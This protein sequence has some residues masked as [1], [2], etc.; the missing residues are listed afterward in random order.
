ML[1]ICRLVRARNA[2]RIFSTTPSPCLSRASPSNWAQRRQPANLLSTAPLPFTSMRAFASK[3][4]TKKEAKDNETKAKKEGQVGNIALWMEEVTKKFDTGRVLFDNM[5]MSFY[6]GAKVGILGVN[7]S[8]KSTMLKILAGVEKDFD[9]K[10]I[11]K[12]GF[13]MGYLAQEP[14]LDEERT[15]ME[16]IMEGVKEK[17]DLLIRYENI[18]NEFADPDLTDD[19]M[20]ELIEE[21]AAL[22]SQIEDQ[23]CWD[24][25]REVG[26]AM[27]ALRCPDP[28]VLCGRL[29]GGQQRR[30]A[31]CRLLLSKPDILLLDEPTNHLD[32]GSVYWLERFLADYK[33]LVI[34]ITHDRYFLDNVA[35]WILEIDGGACYPFKGNYNEWLVN[36]AQRS[37]LT[38]KTDAQMDKTID[39]EITWMQ[40][41]AKGGRT[42]G[43]AREGRLKSMIEERDQ[44]R[45]N[46]RL[47]SGALIIPEGKRLGNNVIK[48]ENLAYS[49]EGRT[50]FKD[51]SFTLG[52][53][54]M[55]GIVG[56]NGTGKT[57]LLK[58]LLG[59]LQPDKGEIEIGS[60]VS[61][62]YNA[63]MRGELQ[64]D[65]IVWKEIC[66]DLNR[67]QIAPGQEMHARQYVAQF[68]FPSD[69]QRKRI[70]Q[71]SGGERN[72]VHLAKSMIKGCNV[73]LLDE[74]TN[75]LDVDTLRNLEEALNDFVAIGAGVVVSHDRWFLDRVCTNILAFEK[76]D[77]IVWFK[78]TY[79]EY[80]E[81]RVKRLGDGSLDG[82]PKY[83]KLA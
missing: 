46:R 65:N 22:I 80:M 64:A 19:K 18:S 21:Q 62:A 54:V 28:D 79:S 37:D 36:R 60:T 45:A 23:M 31:L 81:D 11:T 70:G 76:D 68:N 51:L 69:A 52:Q 6:H 59:E 3:N 5:S 82:K 38:R 4:K 17:K 24:L 56:P 39:R 44:M 41:N 58:M 50:L 20:N 32:A 75:D 72:R 63:Q 8:G 13:K 83:K 67:V 47:E 35:G 73:I 57:T 40:K 55:L 25:D 9:G 1:S 27:E 78:G 7:G 71:L 49:I 43:K 16:N 77:E 48:C 30:V 15:V 34:A 2:R 12:A 26:I 42:K 33:G 74:P 10:S 53:G 29:S 14:E 61:F 66:G